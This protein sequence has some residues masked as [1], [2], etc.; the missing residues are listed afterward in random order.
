M[1]VA[2][3]VANASCA[4]RRR[5]DATAGLAYVQ[6]VRRA[7]GRSD[8][9]RFRAGKKIYENLDA[10]SRDAFSALSRPTWTSRALEYVARL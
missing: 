5:A 10:F 2:M 3:R 9:A 7:V 8:L 4:T 1:N 6:T